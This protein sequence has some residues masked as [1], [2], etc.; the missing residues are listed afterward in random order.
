MTTAQILARA[1]ARQQLR[2]APAMVRALRQ[3]AGL[4]QREVGDALGVTSV[5]VS[6]WERGSRMPRGDLPVRLLDLLHRA[7]GERP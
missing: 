1:K 2:A 5:A 7:C 4:T 3:R 6:L